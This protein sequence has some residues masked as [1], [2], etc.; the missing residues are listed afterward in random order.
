MRTVQCHVERLLVAVQSAVT[1]GW[2]YTWMRSSA[3][4][5]V[6]TA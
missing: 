2:P 5:A 6:E 3:D 4:A 1:Y